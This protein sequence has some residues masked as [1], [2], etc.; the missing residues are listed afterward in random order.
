[1]SVISTDFVFSSSNPPE[2]SNQSSAGGSI[3]LAPTLPN[4]DASKKV[5]RHGP[6]GHGMPLRLLRPGRQLNL[7]AVQQVREDDLDGVARENPPRAGLG[8]VAPAGG[9]LAQ[10]RELVPGLGLGRIAL[11]QLEEPHRVKRVRVVPEL[12]RVDNVVRVDAEEGA[13]GEFGADGE[14]DVLAEPAEEDH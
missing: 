2:P 7:V 9:V 4:H 11:P 1:M 13:C 10:A 14:L 3:S 5:R 12:V 8:T 6:V